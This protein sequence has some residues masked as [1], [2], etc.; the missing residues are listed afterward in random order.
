MGEKV[1][2]KEE[3]KGESDVVKNGEQESSLHN[4]TKVGGG[5]E[6]ANELSTDG[7]K[8]TEKGKKKKAKGAKKK[9]DNGKESVDG[10]N[11][12]E[13]EKEE[14]EGVMQRLKSRLSVR[15]KKRDK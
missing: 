4:D 8:V 2:V 7:G 9:D 10:K 5:K 12:G 15:G 14:E 1:D 3:E 13:K 6:A 11:E